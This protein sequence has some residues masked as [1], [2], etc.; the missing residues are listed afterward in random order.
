MERL[1]ILF[2]VKM[3]FKYL[4]EAYQ[5]KTFENLIL[6]WLIYTKMLLDSFLFHASQ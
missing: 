3:A 5:I 6:A 4:I 2:L 1:V